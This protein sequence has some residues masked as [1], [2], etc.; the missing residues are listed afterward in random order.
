MENTSEFISYLDTYRFLLS[1]VNTTKEEIAAWVFMGSAKGG[2]DAYLKHLDIHSR[3][4]SFDRFYFSHYEQEFDYVGLL[5]GTWF[6]AEEIEHFNPEQENRFISGEALIDRWGTVP[7][8]SARS[9]IAAKI[10]E[11]KLI[12]LHP[13]FGGTKAGSNDLDCYPPLEDGLFSLAEILSIE[14]NEI[15]ESCIDRTQKSEKTKT[16]AHIGSIAFPSPPNRK[17]EWF[18]AIQEAYSQQFIESGETPQLQETWIRLCDDPP[19]Q[20]GI[21]R[22]EYRREPALFLDCKPLTKHAFRERWNRYTS[23]KK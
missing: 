21:T 12:D 1:K 6:A 22:G 2:L 9:F 7:G 20:F 14:K 15:G 8:I 4:P 3:T 10:E 11:S 13:T 5:A 16:L 18:H 23:K 19:R 17:N